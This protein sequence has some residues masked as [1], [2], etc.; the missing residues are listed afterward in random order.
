VPVI[1]ASTDFNTKAAAPAKI[2]ISAMTM[3]LVHETP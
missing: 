1:A 2:R 3:M